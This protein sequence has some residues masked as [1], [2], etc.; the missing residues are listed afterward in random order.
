MYLRIQGKVSYSCRSESTL[1]SSK[2]ISHILGQGSPASERRPRELAITD[3]R[4]VQH[5]R[6]G[7]K[8]SHSKLG[9]I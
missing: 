8:S 6:T 1:I 5:H 3:Q 7:L 9:I 4:A 2:H